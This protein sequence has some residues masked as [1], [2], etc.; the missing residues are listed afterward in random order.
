MR[1]EIA[2]S[3]TGV[4]EIVMFPSGPFDFFYAPHNQVASTVMNMT[5]SLTGW[6]IVI[7]HRRTFTGWIGSLMGCEQRTQSKVVMT[8]SGMLLSR[9]GSCHLPDVGIGGILHS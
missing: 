8:G 7:Y 1:R 6:F 4:N 2:I 5:F 9:V 3:D